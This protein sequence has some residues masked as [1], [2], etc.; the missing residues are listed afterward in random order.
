MSISYHSL[1]SFPQHLPLHG[2]RFLPSFP[3]A[4]VNPR[5]EHPSA[6]SGRVRL[7]S[8]LQYSR[9][10][11][12]LLSFTSPL[13]FT[14]RTPALS[15]MIPSLTVFANGPL[16]PFDTSLFPSPPSPSFLRLPAAQRW[17]QVQN[18]C[19]FPTLLQTGEGSRGPGP[20]YFPPH[21]SELPPHFHTWY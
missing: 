14:T 17:P 12:V 19:P 11:R 18:V 6:L 7:H 2:S 15:T 9:H 5:P 8:R 3:D 13:P 16:T 10:S 21:H 4:R 1:S 20:A